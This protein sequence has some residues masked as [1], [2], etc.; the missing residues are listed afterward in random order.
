VETLVTLLG[1]AGLGL[2]ILYVARRAAP[3]GSRGSLEMLARLPLDRRH[4]LYLVRIADQV[5]LLGAGESGVRK[6][7]EFSGD[8]F[9][10]AAPGSSPGILG[11]LRS[12]RIHSALRQTGNDARLGDMPQHR[13]D[14]AATLAPSQERDDGARPRE[15]RP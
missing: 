13:A 3:I 11:I 5:L 2:V 12:A 10:E 9:P 15:E 1:V 4:S 14:A 7:A 8:T 6:L